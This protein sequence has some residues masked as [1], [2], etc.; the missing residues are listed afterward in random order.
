MRRAR[1]TRTHKQLRREVRGRKISR[2]CHFTQERS[3]PLILE[4]GALR[5]RAVLKLEDLPHHP[6]DSWRADGHLDYISLTIHFPNLYVLDRFRAQDST[7]PW[8][9]VA[10]APAL[11]WQEGTCFCPRNAARH[12]GDGIASGLEAFLSMFEH[13]ET[14]E[15][16]ERRATHLPQCPTDLQAEVLVRSGVR[17][18]DFLGIIVRGPRQEERVRSLIQSF[19][20]RLPIAVSKTMFDRD[21][22]RNA[23]WNGRDIPLPF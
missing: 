9:I 15:W 11:I 13:R 6:N 8:L 21:A 23:A 14:D 18:D 17:S 4:E 16:G 20:V 3:L 19:G 2:L 12:S 5:S 22:V 7:R 1:L 10:C